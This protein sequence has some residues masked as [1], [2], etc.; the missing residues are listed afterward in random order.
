MEK[1]AIIGTACLFPEADTPETYWQNLVANKDSRVS[2]D[3]KHMGRD[4]NDYFSSKK[5]TKD[6]YYCTTGGYVNNF[7]FNPQGYKIEANKL[8]GLDNTFQWALHVSREAL[9]D[10]GYERRFIT[11]WR[12]FR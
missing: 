7:N 8:K 1:I 2:A 10:A 11:L 6:K 3:E 9:K 5:D 4:P 12:Y